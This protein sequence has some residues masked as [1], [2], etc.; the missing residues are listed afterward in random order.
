MSLDLVSETCSFGGL[1]RTYRHSLHRDRHADAVRNL[2]AASGP[3]TA[4]VPLFWFLAGLT[5]TEDNFMQKAGAQRVAAELGLA[6]IAPGYEPSRSRGAG[7][8]GLGF[9]TRRRLLPRRYRSALVRELSGW[10]GT[11]RR[12]FR[13]SSA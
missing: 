12:S 13:R 8:R 3:S 10:A 5:C 7:C 6:L 11:S 1:Q 4:T 2:S 9:R